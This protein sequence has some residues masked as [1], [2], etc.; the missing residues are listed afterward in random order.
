MHPPALGFANSQT[1]GRQQEEK[2]KRPAGEEEEEEE[3]DEEEE[4]ESFR[5]SCLRGLP[6]HADFVGH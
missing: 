4:E 1:H 5:G 6:L 3:E 2:E